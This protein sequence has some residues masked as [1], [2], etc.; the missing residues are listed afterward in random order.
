[1]KESFINTI[2]YAEST[3]N[4]SAM[5][6]VSSRSLIDGSP[7]EFTSSDLAQPSPLASKLFSFPF[8]SGVF[9]ASNF[10]T[11][12]KTVHVEW[13]DIQSNVREFLQDYLSKGLPVLNES[14]VTEKSKIVSGDE[15]TGEKPTSEVDI[16]IVEILDEYIKPAVESDGGAITFK[17]FK[18]GIVTVL[19]QGSCSGCPSS[20]ITLKAGIEALLKRLLPEVNEVVAEEI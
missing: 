16:K 1:M 13:H 20:R 12:S 2:V 6:F 8:V 17:S 7:I 14:V 5:K 11:I 18:N 9:I 15:I 4:P 3:P 19:L 10:V